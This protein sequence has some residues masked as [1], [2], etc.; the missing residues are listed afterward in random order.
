MPLRRLSCQTYCTRIEVRALYAVAYVA[1][2]G[3]ALAL[4]RTL[5]AFA[6]IEPMGSSLS[7]VI[8]LA[9]A[10][11]LVWVGFVFEE[12][13]FWVRM[14][15]REQ[16]LPSWIGQ[17]RSTLLAGFAPPPASLGLALGLLSAMML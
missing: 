3:I 9:C 14:P 8:V 13:F 11:L 4:G 7:F 10:A 16:K 6:G 17:S 12:P 1:T 15:G 2:L 5:A